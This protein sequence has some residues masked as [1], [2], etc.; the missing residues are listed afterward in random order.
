MESKHLTDSEIQGYL[1]RG[2]DGDES[3]ISEHIG[4]C[5]QCREQLELYR[6]LYSALEDDCG[7]GLSAGFAERVASSTINRGVKGFLYRYSD[8]IL[9]I[10]GIAA[11]LVALLH[12]TDL[13]KNIV[14]SSAP[15][16]L[17]PLINTKVF[18]AIRSRAAGATS[19][20]GLAVASV[21]SLATV[22]VIDRFMVRARRKPSSLVV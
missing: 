13:A 14:D 20:V 12:F 11:A 16:W 8:L 17:D 9:V 3:R 6:D 19:T 21:L 5:S 18:A 4:F 1:D 22:W 2:S 7:I 15:E 10:T